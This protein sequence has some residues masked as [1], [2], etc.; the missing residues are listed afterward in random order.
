MVI[1]E[2]RR[3]AILRLSDGSTYKADRYVQGEDGFAKAVFT[4]DITFQTEVSNQHIAS[5]SKGSSDAEARSQSRR[6]KQD[7]G[8]ET[9]ET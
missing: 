8:E 9:D 2:G 7:E 3:E 5:D 1:N 4:D 6:S